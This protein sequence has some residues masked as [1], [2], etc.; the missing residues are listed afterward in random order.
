[1]NSNLIDPKVIHTLELLQP[2]V[3]RD[4]AAAS[5]GKANFL[6]MAA[7]LRS[8][9]SKNQAASLAGWFRQ[10]ASVGS[11][12]VRRPV[13]NTMF[14]ILVAV[15]IFFGAGA[16]TV[17]AAQ[18]SLPDQ[19]LYP[20]KTWSEDALLSLT[21]SPQM[22]V[23]HALNFADRRIAEITGLVAAG[24]PIPAG[25]VSRLQAE[26]D[27]ALD[28]AAGM[29]DPQMVQQLEQIRLRAD[30]QLQAVNTLM[31]DSPQSEQPEL[32]RAQFHIQQQLQMCAAGETDPQEFRLQLRQRMQVR[33][34]NS[35]GTGNES[36]DPAL[37][38]TNSEYRPHKLGVTSTPDGFGP[39]FPGVT[40]TS[41][42][43]G[44]FNPGATPTSDGYGP[45]NPGVTPTS[46]EFGP[47]Q[48]DVAPNPDD[49]GT[50]TPIA[51]PTP[52]GNGSHTPIATPNPYGNGSNTPGATPG[53]GGNGPQ[54]PAGTP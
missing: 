45:F 54:N 53:Q 49:L 41:D 8:A 30:V 36:P 48:P 21:V 43:Y 42:G 15:V 16:T 6:A 47:Y 13:F 3:P 37:T 20:L 26:M 40:P 14:A 10:L 2:A 18:E 50:N 46:N 4:P 38:P 23:N 19:G 7:A 25:V 32:L 39:H 1:M 5:R 9:A 52:L 31:A 24:I 27:Y 11:G 29:E 17:Y 51:T 44:P 33:D 22:G 35:Q 28:L 12:K 34:G